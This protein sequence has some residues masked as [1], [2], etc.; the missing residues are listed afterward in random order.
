MQSQRFMPM[1]CPNL[2]GSTRGICVNIKAA[3]FKPS[4][5]TDLRVK[6]LLPLTGGSCHEDPR[7]QSND[8]DEGLMEGAPPED[9]ECRG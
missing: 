7:A 5:C 4:R 6:W 3:V 8:T 2:Y 9:N 1:R